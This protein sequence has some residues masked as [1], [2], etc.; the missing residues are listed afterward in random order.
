M[1]VRVVD[2]ALRRGVIAELRQF[3]VINTG[4]QEVRIEQW[5]SDRVLKAGDALAVGASAALLVAEGLGDN[6]GCKLPLVEVLLLLDPFGRDEVLGGEPFHL[7][8]HAHS[9]IAS[10]V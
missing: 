9:S 2:E 7:F 10:Q 1:E 5:L 6:P 3:L 8:L 4:Q